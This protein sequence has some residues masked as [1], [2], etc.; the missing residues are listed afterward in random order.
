MLNFDNLGN[1]R[2]NNRIEAKE[3]L[4]GLPESLWETYSAFA[5]TEGGIILLG[6]EELPDKSLHALDILDPQWLLEDFHALL[7]DPD[8]V[9]VNLL[10]P[11]HIRILRVEGN[12]IIAI[13]VP[14]APPERRPVYIGNDPYRG[15]YRRCGEGDY[16]CTREEIEE[17]LAANTDRR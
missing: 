11:E 3:A 12:T 14:K 15:T 4:G 16:R 2:E 9:S 10:R 5:N 7:N 1:Y 17:M 6:V 13:T 8:M